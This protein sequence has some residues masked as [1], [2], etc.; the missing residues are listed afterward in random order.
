MDNNNTFYN[1][2]NDDELAEALKVLQETQYTGENVN[3]QREDFHFEVKDGHK[4]S[5]L[6]CPGGWLTFGGP[7]KSRKSTIMGMLCSA[8]LIPGGTYE[9]IF[10]KMDPRKIV[11]YADTERS[12]FE[13]KKGMD[14]IIKSAG[15]TRKPDNFISHQMVAISD[16]IIRFNSIVAM[17]QTYKE[18]LG[19][20]CIDGIADF[21]PSVMDEKICKEMG[22]ILNGLIKEFNIMLITLVHLNRRDTRLNGSLGVVLDKKSSYISLLEVLD[23]DSPT[24]VS[25]Y[26]KRT[27]ESFKPW[28]FTFGEN[29]LPV[30]IEQTIAP[31]FY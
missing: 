18:D 25:T 2:F 5:G 9:N 24:I 7:E 21:V 30:A 1:R 26:R 16:P 6:L 31:N 14:V 17:I 11:Y 28:Q 19:L 3:L 23:E 20:L 4:W 8:A 22:D 15:L 13:F 27:S 12:R 29:G 10:C